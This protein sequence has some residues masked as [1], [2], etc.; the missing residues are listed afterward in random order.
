MKT[1]IIYFSQTKNTK[2]IAE[3]I[4]DGMRIKQCEVDLIDWMRIK[5]IPVNELLEDCD[6]I[7]IGVPVFFYQLPF[8]IRDWL[9]KFPKENKYYFFFVSYAVVEG[10]ALRDA[11]NILRRKGWKLLDYEKFLGF[12]SY[13]AY[14]SWPRLAVQYP[15]KY[16][17]MKAS[18][19]GELQVIKYVSVINGKDN[20]LSRPPKAPIFW[21]KK[22]WFLNKWVVNK[23]HP[24]FN[25]DASACT[26]C[27][28]CAKNCPDNAIRMVDKKPVFDNSCSRCYF[29]EKGCPDNAIRPDWKSFEK[30]VKKLYEA[31]PDYLKN[32]DE[33]K[34]LCEKHPNHI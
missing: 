13:Q 7:G 1:K 20:F 17:K 23:T 18:Q 30:H 6:L 9:R 24:D 2:E 31:Y 22:K 4:A 34:K 32:N 15:D 12:G 10:T 14:L 28:K 27:G 8:N 33:L 26:G 3:S 19:F 16:E 29:C 11:S 5:D 21:R 25:L